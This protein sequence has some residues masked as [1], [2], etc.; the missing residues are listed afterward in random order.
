MVAQWCHL[1]AT[2]G[3][4]WWRLMG[5]RLVAPGG[6]WWRAW[7]RLVAPGGGGTDSKS[8]VGFLYP[9]AVAVGSDCSELE[10]LGPRLESSQNRLP[11]EL[12]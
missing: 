2:D 12:L 1:V 3:G 9:R 4:S 8:I 7:W 5:A 6:A 10:Q 11:R